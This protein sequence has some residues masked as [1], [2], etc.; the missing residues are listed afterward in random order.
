MRTRL[1]PLKNVIHVEGTGTIESDTVR[2]PI[3]HLLQDA[4]QLSAAHIERIAAYQRERGL[5]FGEAAFALRLAQRSDVVEALSRQFHYTNGFAG[6]EGHSELVTAA[7]PFSD[8]AD[9]FRELRSRLMVEVL[10]DTPRGAICVVSPDAGDGKSYLAANLAV[11]YSQLA[12]PTLLIDADIRTT[13]QH[14]I[15]GVEPGAGLS[16]VLAGFVEASA[17]IRP[18]PTLPSLYLLP[19]GAAPPNPLELLQRPVFP[20]LV[21]DMLDTFEHIVVDTPAATRGADARVIASAC[22]ATLVVARRSRTR[23]DALE[24]LVGALA[25]GP[26]L[27]AGVVMNEH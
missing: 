26:S 20:S 6:L 4:C 24:S 3:G 25:R 5:R 11:A 2:R 15:L 19:G 17:A 14:R 23:M 1:T 18:V 27:F 9:A 16:S 7:D 21:R 13:R 22:S 10:R 12:A 8:Q